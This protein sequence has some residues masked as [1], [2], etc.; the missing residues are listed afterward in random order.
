MI[1]SSSQ[2]EN[3]IS[4]TIEG[5]WESI[6]PVWGRIRSNVRV[7]AMTQ[8]NLPLEQ[9]NILRHIR[10]GSRS[11]S[12]L[13]EAQQISRSA[14]SQVVEMMVSKGLVTRCQQTQ[15]RRFVQLALTDSGNALL[16]AIF[17]KNRAWM[18]EK[19]ADLSTDELEA[20]QRGMELLKRSFKQ[21]GL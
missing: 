12:D 4:E 9:Y 19:M 6:P 20:I 3:P 11:V 10:K 1:I 2:A 14:V 7:I 16:D 15:D 13:A 21:S 17:E 5:F 18:A 8:F